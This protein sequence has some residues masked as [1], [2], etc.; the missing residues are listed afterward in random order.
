MQ[1]VLAP[2]GRFILGH[3]NNSAALI[4]VSNRD[5][6][7]IFEK[8]P[9]P[10]FYQRQISAKAA[11]NRYLWCYSTGGKGVIED[12]GPDGS[13]ATPVSRLWLGGSI[14]CHSSG[15]T[16]D[17]DQFFVSC[18]GAIYLVDPS[19][20]NIC[21]RLFKER[22]TYKIAYPTPLD[23]GAPEIIGD[24]LFLCD[25]LRGFIRIYKWESADH[26]IPPTHIK[27]A[28]IKGYPTLPVMIDKRVY[29]PLGYAGILAFD[30]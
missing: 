13:F 12:F 1:T 17:G 3:I 20:E 7:R 24:Y 29:I 9:Y 16:A 4:D 6:V 14:P 15:I 22:G 30:L 28:K 23:T 5:N 26:S 2:G 11:K 10:M 19:D 27:T 21:T 25:R 8:Y 18:Q